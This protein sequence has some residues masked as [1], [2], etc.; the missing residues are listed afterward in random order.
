MKLFS[1]HSVAKFEQ[2]LKG[3]RFGD[4]K[5]F[6][7]KRLKAEKGSLSAK[8]SE[9][10]LLRNTCKKKLAHTRGF[11]HESSRFKNK[12]LT[13]RPRTPELCDLWAET[14]E[15]SPEKKAPAL[16]QNT[17]LLQV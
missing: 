14:R 13:T 9:N 10:V 15:L 6:S 7:K 17:C 4:I 2:K 16:S 5:M 11:K 8:K 3:K 12:H 1:I